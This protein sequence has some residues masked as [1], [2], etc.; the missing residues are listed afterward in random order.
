[1][2]IIAI[3]GVYWKAIEVT[4][5]PSAPYGTNVDAFHIARLAFRNVNISK[6]ASRSDERSGASTYLDFENR[7]SQWVARRR[8]L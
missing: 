1:M 8:E 7:R 5:K 3:I 4:V 6:F 2:I